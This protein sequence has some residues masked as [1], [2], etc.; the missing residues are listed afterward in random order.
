MYMSGLPPLPPL[1]WEGVICDAISKKFEIEFMLTSDKQTMQ[2]HILFVTDAGSRIL[3]GIMPGSGWNEV[4]VGQIKNVTVT[5]RAF[6]PDAGFDRRD[7]R[8]YNVL[9]SV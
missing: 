4:L 8:Y 6:K 2:P 7:P 1:P 5:Q 9:C 3:R